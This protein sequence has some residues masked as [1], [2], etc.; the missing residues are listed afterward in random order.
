MRPRPSASGAAPAAPCTTSG[1]SAG[2]GPWAREQRPS[3][4]PSRARQRRPRRRP[5]PSRPQPLLPCPRPS[6]SPSSPRARPRSTPT[7]A[8]FPTPPPRTPPSPQTLSFRLP[9]RRP[10]AP[11]ATRWRQAPSISRPPTLRLRAPPRCSRPGPRRFAVRATRRSLP[12]WRPTRT[13]RPPMRPCW[14]PR[15]RSARPDPARPTPIPSMRRTTRTWT[16][17]SACSP[18]PP[19]SASS[20]TARATLPGW[21]PRP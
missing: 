10:R 18:T 3:S 4:S 1:T 16:P 9:W 21:R 6:P 11:C 19:R 8:W 20:V 17:A 15:W 12:P 13:P 2:L 14:P 5:R 7:G